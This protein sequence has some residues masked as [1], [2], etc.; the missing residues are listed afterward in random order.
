MS[1]N[2]NSLLTLPWEKYSKPAVFRNLENIESFSAIV[3]F[4]QFVDM[5]DQEHRERIIDRLYQEVFAVLSEVKLGG[6]EMLERFSRDSTTGESDAGVRYK[7]DTWGFDL[8]LGG[9][10]QLVLARTGSSFERF[11]DWYLLL[12]PFYKRFVQALQEEY[13]EIVNSKRGSE[14]RVKP[15]RSSYVFRFLLHDFDK[16]NRQKRVKNTELLRAALTKV[17]GSDGSL[18]DLTDDVLPELGRV[19]VQISRWNKTAAGPVREI[20]EIIAP[21]NRDYGALWIRFSYVGETADGEVAPRQIIDM[22]QF[23][24]QVDLPLSDFLQMRCLVNF[25]GT[26]STGVGFKSSA[27][28]LP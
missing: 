7:D 14:L 18:V 5:G 4:P 15:S 21:A 12:M 11:Y 27:G 23:I 22:D 24:S 28:A 19:D 25:L 6:Y 8:Y 3:Q 2:G 17:P 16:P 13:E 20:Y 9:D 1:Q 10:Q 26:L